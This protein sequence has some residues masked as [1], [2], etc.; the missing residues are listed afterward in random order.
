MIQ[1]IQ[2]VYLLVGA[3]ACAVPL[4]VGVAPL[5]GEATPW[6]GTLRTSLFVLASTLGIA[7]IFLFGKRQVQASLVL[8]AQVVAALSLLFLAGASL[9]Y[10]AEGAGIESLVGTGAA[11]AATAAPLVAL[12]LYGLARRA[13]K[14]DVK[15]VKSMDRLRD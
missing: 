9:L 2:T 15:L 13:I 7:A 12:V 14:A 10:S 5:G 11:T 4:V 3:I 6:V 1:R 8:W